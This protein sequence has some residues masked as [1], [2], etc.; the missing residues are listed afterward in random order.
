MTLGIIITLCPAWAS[1]QYNLGGGHVPLT[2]KK[3]RL[4]PPT[5]AIKI[6]VHDWS[7][8]RSGQRSFFPLLHNQIRSILSVGGIPIAIEIHSAFSWF[9][10]HHTPDSTPILFD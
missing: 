2:L 5:F 8:L 6:L 4:D 3:S 1:P 10:T 7:T 9:P